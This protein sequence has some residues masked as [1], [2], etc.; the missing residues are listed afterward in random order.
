METSL[1][2]RRRIL[3]LYRELSRLTRGYILPEHIRALKRIWAE[4]LQ[5]ERVVRS[6]QKIHPLEHSLSTALILAREAGMRRS[7]VISAILFNDDLLRGL[8]LDEAERV[9]GAATA[10]ILRGLTRAGELSGHDKALEN[11]HFKHLLLSFAQDGRAIVILIADCVNRMRRLGDYS[12]EQQAEIAHSAGLLYAPL[13]HRMGLYAMKTELED[14]TLKYTQPAVF[15]EIT[16]KLAESKA[17]REAYISRFIQPVRDALASAIDVPFEIKG[18]TK[19]VH[20]IW[21]KIKNKQ[22]SF[23]DIYDIFAIRIIIDA[24]PQREKSLCWHAFSII[25]DMYQSNPARTRDWLSI[26]KSNGYES[27]HTTV[28][29]PED[30]WVEVQIRTV[31]MNE[32]AEKGLAAHWRYKGIKS[33]KGLDE[34]LTHIREV[35]ENH[36]PQRTDDFKMNLYDDEIYVF[37]PKGELY[38]LPQGATVLDFAYGIHTALGNRSVGARVNGRNVPIRYRLKSGDT[39]EVQTAANQTPRQDWL[40]YVVT[41]KARNKIRQTLKENMQK[42]A[43]FGRDNLVRRLKNRKLELDEAYLMRL[44]KRFRRKSVTDFFAEIGEGRLDT[45]QVIEAYL[46]MLAQDKGLS[47]TDNT[48]L[49]ASNFAFEPSEEQLSGSREDVLVIDQNLKGL[50][51]K[52][53]KCCH[54]IYG[55]EVFGFVSVT[56]GIKVH[57]TDCPNAP[58]MRQRYGYRMVRARWAGQS[59]DS[60]YEATLQVIGKDDIGIVTNITS[61]IS[62]ENDVSMR[63]I[64]IDSDDGLFCGWLTVMVPNSRQL[65]SLI[66][67]IQTVKGVKQVLRS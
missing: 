65:D 48:A 12:E 56:G 22:I 41:T 19:S 9:F 18:R 55:D 52:L 47:V 64:R 2:E 27:L 4:A 36:D 59:K 66:K 39:I 35:I 29:G 26:P 54:P 31:R 3:T 15:A 34:M 6:E 7:S 61:L 25:T 58:Q 13:A 63:S 46:E 10:N 51:F 33:E 37:S 24:P 21:N 28:L 8:S 67:K 5:S 44:V 11:E 38:K 14:L 32:I 30:K 62:K 60:Q 43:E 1:R 53:A 16:R 17:A 49:S 50:E 45:N 20:S 42:L 40:N 23:E 57:R